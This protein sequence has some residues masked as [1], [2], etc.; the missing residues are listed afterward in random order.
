MFPIKFKPSNA[1]KII[2]KD[3]VKGFLSI[4]KISFMQ[5]NIPGKLQVNLES[6]GIIF[7][8]TNVNGGIA[9]IFLDP[10][11]KTISFIEP[12]KWHY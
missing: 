10:L 9:I 11:E 1:F 8:L 3:Q 4:E 12:G 6:D 2:R 5:P 7:E